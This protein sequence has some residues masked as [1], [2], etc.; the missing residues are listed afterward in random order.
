MKIGILA[1]QGRAGEDYSYLEGF[2]DAEGTWAALAERAFVRRLDGGCSSPVAAYAKI[3]GEQMTLTGLYYKEEDQ[4]CLTGSMSGNVR[5]AEQ[6]GTALADRLRA[7]A[8]ER[9]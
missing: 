5:D 2:S 4:T 3:E 1:V 7:E 6:M 8:E 9:V